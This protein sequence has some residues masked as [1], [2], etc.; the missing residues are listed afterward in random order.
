M[1][2]GWVTGPG[3][4]LSFKNCLGCFADCV[5]CGKT[6]THGLPF[7]PFESEQCPSAKHGFLTLTPMHIASEAPAS[8]FIIDSFRI[9][10][11]QFVFLVDGKQ[12][13]LT[14]HLCVAISIINARVL[15]MSP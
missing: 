2:P 6:Q 4:H 1:V 10:W 7:S 12:K 3:W 8:D 14:L 5:H 13:Q 15:E 11:L 9:L